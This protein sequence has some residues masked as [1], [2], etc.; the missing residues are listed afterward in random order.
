MKPFGTLKQS[1]QKSLNL[2]QTNSN[3]ATPKYK[4]TRL[5]STFCESYN[6]RKQCVS[7]FNSALTSEI[8]HPYSKLISKQ[9]RLNQPWDKP[10]MKS[11]LLQNRFGNLLEKNR[12]VKENKSETKVHLQGSSNK[13]QQQPF[14]C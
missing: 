13:Y 7:D 10:Q 8:L 11:K 9:D 12:S 3:A 1:S 6:G 2:S 5:F 14:I 4:N